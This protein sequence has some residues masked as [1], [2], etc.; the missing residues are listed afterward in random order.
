[1]P[2]RAQPIANFTTGITRQREK[3]GASPNSL[4]DLVNA[5]IDSS[6]S[7]VCR[8]AAAYDQR[9]VSG[10]V[11]ICAFADK[12][13]V[14]AMTPL[15]IS[16]PLYEVDVLIHPDPAFT[17]SLK[18]IYFAK[19]FL[20]YLYIVAEFSDGSIYHYWLQKPAAWLPNTIYPINGTV[21]PTTPNG[22]LYTAKTPVTAPVWQPNTVYNI[23]D[24][25]QPSTPNGY[26][27]T[28]TST[29]GAAAASGD[30]EP[31]W[32][33]QDGAQ[34]FEETDSTTVPSTGQAT[35]TSSVTVP[36][37]VF[38]RYGNSIQVNSQ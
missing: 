16:N 32:P 6:G 10:T 23:G 37:V 12:L 38:D 25:I 4:Y 34:V 36:P 26:L 3:G 7:A 11:S 33:A 2:A 20:G 22:Y 29:A 8:D 28:I 24:V 30:T 15:T 5:Y 9:L 21:I 35:T 14:F 19:P 13:H 18:Y 17:G 1:M 27:Y 31:D